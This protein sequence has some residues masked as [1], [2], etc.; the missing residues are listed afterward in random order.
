MYKLTIITVTYNNREE[1]ERT[2]QSISTGLNESNISKIQ[3]VVVDGGTHDFVLPASIPALELKVISERDSG[4]FDAMN[5]G[6]S[7]ADGEFCLFL[8]SGDTF[9]DEYTIDILISNIET[10]DAK[11]NIVAGS[12]KMVYKDIEKT[13]DLSPW[14]CHQAALIR[15]IVLKEYKFNEGLRY[16]GDL[17]L[18]MR[19]NS[20]AKLVFKRINVVIAVF[21][22]GGLG[23]NPKNIFKRLRERNSLMSSLW[24]SLKRTAIFLCLWAIYKVLGKDYYYKTVM[25][26]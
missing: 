9:F 6:I 23:N 13:S 18:W 16:F 3:L 10:L 22:M 7:M 25:S 1:L 8:N 20:D 5:K 12:V 24:Q 26:R 19:L 2:I 21:E 14:F 17:D 4:V 15:S 11:F